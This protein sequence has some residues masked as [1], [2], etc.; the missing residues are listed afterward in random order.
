M[1]T[2][3]HFAFLSISLVALG[4]T[5]AP[6]VAFAGGCPTCTSSADCVATEDGGVAFCVLHDSE[7]GCGAEVMLCCPGQGCGIT[8]EGRPSC[9]GTSC[10]V[11]GEAMPDGGPMDVDA[12]PTGSDGGASGTDAGA[13]AD[14]GPTG[15]GDGGGTTMPPDGGTTTEDDGGCGCRIAAPQRNV[16]GMLAVAGAIALVIAR[17]RRR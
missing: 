1:R 13:G 5:T 15:G 12:G 17:R 3:S 2:F 6:G 10:S 4:A 8:A 7:V 9:E 14:G 11:V 16:G